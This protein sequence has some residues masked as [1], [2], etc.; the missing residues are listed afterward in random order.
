MRGSFRQ[1]RRLKW[2]DRRLLLRAAWS[3]GIIDLSVRFLP[4]RVLFPKELA[5][6]EGGTSPAVLSRART[7][8]SAI[9]LASRHHIVRA[10]CLHRS[11]VLHGWLRR[12]GL[13][14]RLRIG[15]RKEGAELKAHAWVELGNEVVNDYP[16][17]IAAFVPLATPDA[18]KLWRQTNE[19]R[20]EQPRSG[21]A[22]RSY[23]KGLN[24]D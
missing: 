8:A 13:P 12:E 11:L 9:E 10:Q 15:V 3:L 21:E 23:G 1:W 22:A 19:L 18:V 4:P 24:H 7:Y 5:D 17:S 6:V 14:S 2:T 16:E 20:A